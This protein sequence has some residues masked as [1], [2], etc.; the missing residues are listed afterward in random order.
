MI[1]LVG[2]MKWNRM[3]GSEAKTL[4]FSQLMP[5]FLPFL[6]V[7]WD[8]ES[9]CYTGISVKRTRDKAFGKAETYSVFFLKSIL[10]VRTLITDLNPQ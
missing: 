9:K 2:L 8:W 7:F 3:P 1:F 6:I 4:V 10:T 5:S